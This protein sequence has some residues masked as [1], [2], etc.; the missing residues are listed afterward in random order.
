MGVSKQ[1]LKDELL[2][3]LEHERDTLTAAQRA[4]TEGLTHE[5]ARPESDKDTRATEASYLARGQAK[6]V[7]ELTAD[8]ERVRGMRVRDFD[9]DD[10]IGICAVIDIADADG[11]PK[12]TLFMAPAGGGITLATD[13]DSVRVVTPRAPLGRA[14]LQ[15]RAGEIVEVER[16]GRTEEIEVVAVR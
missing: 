8:T 12:G 3:L 7:E 5:D 6:R 9:A 4:T 16:G 15:A 1:A 10:P 11:N 14:L 13:D 2:R